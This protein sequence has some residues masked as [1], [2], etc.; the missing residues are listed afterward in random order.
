MHVHLKLQYLSLLLQDF[1]FYL[2]E[3]LFLEVASSVT[4]KAAYLKVKVY[5]ND[6]S[7]RKN[8]F[9]KKMHISTKKVYSMMR[10]AKIF[11]NFKTT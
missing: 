7:I 6:Q 8:S 11:E 1:T 2:F 4:I 5:T 9:L 3:A 10:Y